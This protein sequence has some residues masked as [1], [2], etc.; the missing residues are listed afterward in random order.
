MESADTEHFTEN[1]VG[2][3][4]SEVL[5]KCECRA[6]VKSFDSGGKAGSAV[7]QLCDLRQIP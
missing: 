7:S 2:Q 5:N 1:S 4:C 3:R 6:V